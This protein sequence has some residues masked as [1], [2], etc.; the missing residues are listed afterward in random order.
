MF[1]YLR[2]GQH[3]AVGEG[4]LAGAVDFGDPGLMHYAEGI[5]R[6]D[7]CTGEN[8]NTPSSGSLEGAEGGDALLG[9]GLAAGSEDAMATAAD[10]GFESLERV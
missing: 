4:T 8:N 6:R 7:T 9:R 2:V 1:Y 10:D 3:G 5:L